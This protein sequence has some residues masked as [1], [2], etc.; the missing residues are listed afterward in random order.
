MSQKSPHVSTWLTIMACV[1]GLLIQNM[2]ILPHPMVAPSHSSPSGGVLGRMARRSAPGQR[3]GRGKKSDSTSAVAVAGAS[4]APASDL[5]PLP[6]P[7]FSLFSLSL[8]WLPPLLIS[9]WLLLWSRCTCNLGKK[10]SVSM[11][12]SS[13][14][15]SKKA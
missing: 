8:F 1:R 13:C 7:L 6:R 5:L 2:W 10:S 12:C 4:P 15:A 11:G 3:H 14:A 9:L